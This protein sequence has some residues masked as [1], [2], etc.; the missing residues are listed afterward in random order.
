M[1]ADAFGEWN[2][3]EGVVMKRPAAKGGAK[4]AAKGKP[5][6]P[7]AIEDG[8]ASSAGGSDS[9]TVMKKPGGKCVLV[10]K[11]SAPASSDGGSR[12]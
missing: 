3:C 5:A 10:R 2:D 7:A 11:P 1:L 4:T 8:K 6:P 9:P 12:E